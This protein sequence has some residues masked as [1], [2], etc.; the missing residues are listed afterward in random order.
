MGAGERA[1]IEARADHLLPACFQAR[2][3]GKAPA[4]YIPA[5][6]DKE[7]ARKCASPLIA[8]PVDELAIVR[9]RWAAELGA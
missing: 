6:A 3:E 9:A 7:C 8:E 4:E 2:V 1:E 5:E